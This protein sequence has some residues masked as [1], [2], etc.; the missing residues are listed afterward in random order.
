M[1]NKDNEICIYLNSDGDCALAGDFVDCPDT[2]GECSL[3]N[4]YQEHKRGMLNV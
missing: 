3:Y 4:G 2:P 1:Q